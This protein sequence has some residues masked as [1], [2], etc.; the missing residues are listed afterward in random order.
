MKN[1]SITLK[2]T[3]FIVMFVGLWYGYKAVQFTALF[4]W[5]VSIAIDL[6]ALLANKMNNGKN[7]KENIK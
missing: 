7:A 5:F 4:F 6:I 3:G 2:I 1:I